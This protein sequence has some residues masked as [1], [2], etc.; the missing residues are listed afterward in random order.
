MATLVFGKD[1]R[2]TCEKCDEPVNIGDSFCPNCGF[3]LLQNKGKPA[4]QKTP[5]HSGFSPR[6]RGKN[7]IARRI[8][9]NLEK[10]RVL[11]RMCCDQHYLDIKGHEF[12]SK[13]IGEAGKMVGGWR[14]QQEKKGR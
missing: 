11:L 3:K 10:L 4:T 8:D 13:K 9:L 5:G 2:I 12:A 1:K 6:V 14:N 7:E